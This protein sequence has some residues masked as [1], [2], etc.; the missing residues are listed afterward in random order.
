MRPINLI[1]MSQSDAGYPVWLAPPTPNSGSPN[2]RV[3]YDWLH[4]VDK[5]HIRAKGAGH[6]A[7][8]LNAQALYDANFMHNSS[9]GKFHDWKDLW[10]RE[11]GKTCAMLCPGPSLKAPPKDENAFSMGLN[12]SITLK[13]DYYFAI[14]R[15]GDPSWVVGSCPDTTLI[16]STGVCRYAV[17]NAY[18]ES[19]WGEHYVVEEPSNC[20]CMAAFLQITLCDAMFA[21]YKLGAKQVDL[22]GANF[23]ILGEKMDGRQIKNAA[24][25]FNAG[26]EEGMKVRNPKTQVFA[27]TGIGG[28]T[29]LVTW[30]LV[31]QAAYAT[32]MADMLTRSGCTV[33]NRSERGILWE[34][35][36]EED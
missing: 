15:R 14:D 4:E 9:L 31:V 27:I 33:R 19:Y 10:G 36:L 7:R 35:W 21:A 1:M 29:V 3:V 24:Y 26:I 11:K 22:Y 28:E 25:Y 18:K 13:P 34:T 23:A 6:V 32:I 5:W 20:T 12:R 30:D 8:P 16:A 2:L 17:E